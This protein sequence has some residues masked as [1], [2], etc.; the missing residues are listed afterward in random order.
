MKLTEDII[1]DVF[2][3]NK[4]FLHYVAKINGY[5]FKNQEAVDR[6]H[7]YAAENITK[8]YQKD[9]DFESNE[10]MYGYIIKSFS[11]GIMRSFKQGKKAEF[12]D[13]MSVES[14]LIY[15]EDDSYNVFLNNAVSNDIEYD[16][17]DQVL[18]R[19]IESV[20]S[21]NEKKIIRLKLDGFNTTEIAKELDFSV[22]YVNERIKGIKKKYKKTKL[23]IKKKRQDEIQ[24]EIAARY[25]RQN[26]ERLRIEAQRKRDEEIKKARDRAAKALLWID[27]AY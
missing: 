3:R 26:A 11:Y 16:N 24:K 23:E 20:C 13:A 19:E 1:R 10:H 18:L 5:A 17:S 22:S 2:P 25:D 21:D 14:D 9:I 8:L 12:N 7:Y 4:R 27:S 6:A 15:G